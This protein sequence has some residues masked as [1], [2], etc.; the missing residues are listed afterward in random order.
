MAAV[1]ILKYENGYKLNVH[2]IG[3]MSNNA[4]K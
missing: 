3:A 4:Q 2:L 1:F